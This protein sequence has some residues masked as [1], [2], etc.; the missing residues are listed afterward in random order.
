MHHRVRKC[1][2]GSMTSLCDRIV[3]TWVAY[4][5]LDEAPPPPAPKKM[6]YEMSV[7]P[8][9]I[10]EDSLGPMAKAGRPEVFPSPW[11]VVSCMGL[12]VGVSLVL[13]LSISGSLPHWQDMG[14]E[15][16]RG[17]PPWPWAQ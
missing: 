5:A 3:G 1:N 10:P 14:R 16:P 2:H 6:W 9:A 11:S 17:A 15:R 12:L 13:E 4:K 7:D 8:A